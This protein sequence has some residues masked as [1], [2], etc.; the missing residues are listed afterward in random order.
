M[1]SRARLLAAIRYEPVDHTPLLAWCFGFA[2][3]P[4][5]C[6]QRTGRAVAHW[7]TGRLEHIHTLPEP[8]QLPE[9]DFAR[10]RAFL[11]LGLDDMIEVSVPWSLS[12]QVEVRD[13]QEPPS[14]REPYP[15]LCREYQTPAGPLRHSVRSTRERLE[16]G[17][18]V[19]PDEVQ[20]LEDFN[21]PRGVK[22]ALAGP[23]DLAPLA[24]LLGDPTPEQAVVY[25]TRMAAIRAFAEAEGV[26][27]QGW[28]AFGMDMAVWL[29]GVEPAVLAGVNDP[30]YFQAVLNVI[31]DFDRRRT[32]FLLAEGG[33]DMVVQRGWY[34]ST[35]FWSPKLFRRYMLPMLADRAAQAH[36]AGALFAYTMT[37]GALPMADSLLEAGVDLLYYLDPPD[38]RSDMAA[39]K[40]RCA[41]K[42]ALAGGISSGVT[43][44]S[45]QPAAVR[46][47]VQQS[48]VVLAP[49][50]GFILAPV[51]ALFPH[52]PWQSVQ[53]M[54]EAWRDCT[55][56]A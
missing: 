21:I 51:D 37:T 45:G 20:L 31:A 6:W 17:W 5:L 50:S 33:V 46:Q 16:P 52:T 11:S 15:L 19:Q 44:A 2:P 54:I 1:E 38:A 12:P 32:A 40:H 3:P 28:S 49:G 10:V 8:W 4:E 30:D 18:V 26:M 47:A 39:V 23:A 22:H 43:L 25:R 53:A 55:A 9:D 56:G 14:A 36:A 41:G 34:S 48:M 13:W 27:V 7:Y 42:L 24:Y 35:D 29:M